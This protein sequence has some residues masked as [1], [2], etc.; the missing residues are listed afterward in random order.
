MQSYQVLHGYSL[1]RFCGG[2]Y[3]CRRV[4]TNFLA[5]R[6]RILSWKHSI[7]RPYTMSEPWNVTRAMRITATDWAQ[8]GLPVAN[9]RSQYSRFRGPLRLTRFS[10]ARIKIWAAPMQ[11]SSR[12][13]EPKKC[14]RS[15]W[16]YSRTFLTETS[17]GIGS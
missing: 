4:R 6:C 8:R 5:P 14:S 2:R 11:T 13:K 12:L 1:S 7:L 10:P 3:C 17:L 9:P 15:C 16:I